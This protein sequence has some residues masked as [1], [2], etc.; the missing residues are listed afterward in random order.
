M[1][2]ADSEHVGSVRLERQALQ[3]Y[4]DSLP[5]LGDADSFQRRV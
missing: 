2:L 4:R 1:A 5:F 3:R